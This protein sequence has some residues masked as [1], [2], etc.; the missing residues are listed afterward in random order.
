MFVPR[1]AAQEEFVNQTQIEIGGRTLTAETGRVA[2]QASGAVTVRMGDTMLLTT[3]VMASA[4]REGIDFFPL[5]CDYEEKLYAAGKIPGG[6]IRREGRP[7]EQAILNSRL[8]DRPIRPLFPKD[9]RNDV[10]VVATVLSVDQ[11]SDPAILAIN[12]ASLALS[13][14]AIPFQGPIGAVR[15]GLLDDQLVVNPPVN[16]MDESKLD[17]VV[18]GTKEAIIMVEAGA[19]EVPEEQIVE[20]LRV[21]HREIV[22]LCEW[23]Q[24]FAAEVGKPK[25]EVAPSPKDADVDQAVDQFLA[26]RLDQA[27]FNPNKALRESALDDLKKETVTELGPQFADR[28]P[29]LSKS[30]EAKV[31]ERVRGKILDEGMRPDGRK[32]TEIRAISCEV[33]L[34]PR[35]HGSALFTRG[36]TQALSIVTLGSIGDK[37]KLDGLGL[38]EFKRFMHHYN[39]PPFSVGEARPL[40]SP[41][42]REIG[43][44]ALAERALLPVVPTE[45]EF[46]YTIRLVTE[47]LSSNGSTSMASVCGSSLAMMDAG[48]P[49]KGQVA[50]IAM[51]LI[52]GNGKVAVLSDIQG[53]EDALGDMDFKVAGTRRGVTAM[54]MDMKIKG[55]SIETMAGAI[56]QAKEGRFFI[57]DKMNAAISEP[58]TAMSQYAPRMLT[59]Q[60]HPD[61]I[62]E[63]IG[64]GGK[65]IR[66]IIEESGV[67]SIDIED[68]GRVVIGSVNGESAAKAEQM[69]HDLTG[70]VEVGKNYK[71]KVVRVMPFGAFFQIL[72]NVDGLVHISQLAE[73]RV[74]RVEDVANVGDEIEVKV[75]EVDRQ[76]RVNLS[77]KAVIQEAKGITNGDWIVTERDRGGPRREG[78]GGGGYRGGGDR[79]PRREFDR[80]GSRGGDHR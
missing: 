70:E 66:K 7:S 20:A 18:A 48:V 73:E 19:K 74:G 26:A 36:Q 77:R 37:Q 35:T 71:G 23:Q 55:I 22:R 76:G 31:K 78:G 15:I 43:H 56:Q 53:I 67:T 13:I 29:Y 33:G 52:T 25:V 4:P 46:P 10:Q 57:M 5:T 32:T 54:Q 69:I 62:R 24:A 6:F 11:E 60:I 16:R 27:L 34:L 21:A 65:M 42:R 68:D 17:L 40:R 58:R 47:I 12:G 75:T 79:G 39:F 72:P 51:G 44:G 63:V 38:E 8:I 3:S 45:E 28:L 41:G 50:G 9:F 64:P 14:S 30:F 2:Q 59:I 80:A 1:I 61:K 49:T